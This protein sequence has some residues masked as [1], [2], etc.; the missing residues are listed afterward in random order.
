MPANNRQSSANRLLISC[1]G[2]FPFILFILR[3]ISNFT[4]HHTAYFRQTSLRSLTKSAKEK[5]VAHSTGSTDAL[6]MQQQQ[7]QTEIHSAIKIKKSIA[8][9]GILFDSLTHTCTHLFSLL[10]KFGGL[11]GGLAGFVA[12]PH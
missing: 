9:T 7:K 4:N 12:T 10:T 3:L 5:F 8:S 11:M 2:I 1:G 6:P